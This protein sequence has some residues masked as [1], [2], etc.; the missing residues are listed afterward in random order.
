MPDQSAINVLAAFKREDAGT[1]GVPAAEGAGAQQ[2][3]ILDS[4]GLRLDRGII[5]SNERRNDLLRPMGRLGGKSVGGSYNFELTL[6]GMTDDF[7][8]AI[9]RNSWTPALAIPQATFGASAT[10]T[11]S[12]SGSNTVLTFSAG[13]PITQGIRVGDVITLAGITGALVG[14]NNINFIVIA[15]TATSITVVGSLAIGVSAG[16][17]TL[18]RLKKIGNPTL[19]V[20]VS[21]TAE[22]YDEDIDLS[23]LFL[24]VRLVR[25][26]LS[27]RPNAV[28]TYA[29]TFLG[30]DRQLLMVG[31][32]PYFTSPAVT[33]GLPLIA[34]DSSIR[35]NGVQQTKF[36]AM[37]LTLEIAGALQP[38]IGSM[39]SPDVFLND[40]TISGSISGVRSDF[41][42]LIAF[43]AETEFEMHALFTEPGTAPLG[44]LG[45]YLPRVK[46]GTPDAPFMGGDAAK[47]ETLPLIVAPRAAATGYDA[48]AINFFSSAA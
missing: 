4:P 6:G 20:G 48:T 7:L 40:M 8:S 18:T 33:T 22:Q 5:Q 36:T 15:V 1:P 9:L 42:R 45:L 2:L 28:A 46:F 27:F 37:D 34:D 24:G 25:L 43:D 29:A 21:Y 26:A 13:N 35:S 44:A 39:T 10:I 30:M 38:V 3:R 23:E 47:V 41:T 19:P 17:W 32:S 16:A 12:A 11:T 14:L 31:T